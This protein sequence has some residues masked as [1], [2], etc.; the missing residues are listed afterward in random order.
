MS[1]HPSGP[2]RT[3]LTLR[4][5]EPRL[6]AAERD[7]GGNVVA[8]KYVRALPALLCR[9]SLPGI[10]T[11]PACGKS[12]SQAV[13]DGGGGAT[14]REGRRKRNPALRRATSR[15][16]RGKE[17]EFD[18][19]EINRWL[20]CSSCRP[21]AGR[22][23]SVPPAANRWHFMTGSDQAMQRFFEWLP[24]SLNGTDCNANKAALC[25]TGAIIEHN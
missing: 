20:H 3:S 25:S 13:S 14:S 24:L 5:E 12:K 16:L 22:R 2:R 8:G 19:L 21:S 11:R 1:F 18:T 23:C 6:M 10:R 7:N 4:E 15:S 17:G 9:P